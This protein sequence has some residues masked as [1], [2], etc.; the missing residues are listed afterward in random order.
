MLG[1]Q[2]LTRLNI[3]EIETIYQHQIQPW[4]NFSLEVNNMKMKKENAREI[5]THQIA[6]KKNNSENLLFTDGSSIPEQG[7]AAAA[8]LNNST[9]FACRINNAEDSSSF[10]AEVTAINIGLEMFKNNLNNL[11]SGN[12]HTIFDKQLN[13]F[14]DNQATLTTISKP[15]KSTSL[16]FRFNKIFTLL[17]FISSNSTTPIQLFWCP[18]HVGIPENEKVD[19]LAKE[20]TSDIQQFHLENQ[21]Q[22]L[23]NLQQKIRQQYK[24]NKSKNPLGVDCTYFKSWRFVSSQECNCLFPST[25]SPQPTN[26]RTAILLR[27]IPLT[28]LEVGTSKDKRSHSWF[29]SDRLIRVISPAVLRDL[30]NLKLFAGGEAISEISTLLHKSQLSPTQSKTATPITKKQH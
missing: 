20:A 10:E 6:Q 11:L 2:S 29:H 15:P 7:T 12:Q 22:T 26:A 27:M 23:T 18:A 8:L 3:S 4:E 28:Q 30:H 1:Q 9:S 25:E 17:K 21:P 24:F 13:I 5:V 19:S 16:Q 14:C